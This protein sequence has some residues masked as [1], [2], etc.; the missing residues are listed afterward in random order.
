M[1]LSLTGIQ[2]GGEIGSEGGFVGAAQR[3]QDC[4]GCTCHGGKLW[5]DRAE[6]RGKGV[7]PVAEA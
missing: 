6:L 5:H 1:G 4:Q 3:P 2:A 7:H